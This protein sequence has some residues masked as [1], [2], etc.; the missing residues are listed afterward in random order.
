MRTSVAKLLRAPALA[1]ALVTPALAAGWPAGTELT[2]LSG[3]GARVVGIGLVSEERITLTL[4]RE[5]RGV[6]V[7]MIETPDG[8]LTAFDCMVADDGTVYLSEA[9]SVS[10]LSDHAAEAGK[11]VRIGYGEPGQALAGAGAD[12]ATEAGSAGPEAAVSGAESEA[13]AA[14][15]D[16]QAPGEPAAGPGGREGVGP[17]EPAREV[18]VG[19]PDRPAEPTGDAAGEAGTGEGDE[20]ERGPGRAVRQAGE[21]LGNAVEDLVRRVGGAFG[22]DE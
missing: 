15:V 3:D 20:P 21:A 7:L 1:L 8:Q 12:D 14:A 22:G 13:P 5:F 17:A 19:L 9:G 10:D 4:S 18:E 11:Q 2:M 16:A 6:A